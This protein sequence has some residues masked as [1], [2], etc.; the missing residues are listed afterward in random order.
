MSLRKVLSIHATSLS[1][2]KGMNRLINL[3]R[4]SA[5]LIIYIYKYVFLGLSYLN[6]FPSRN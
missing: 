6:N 2:F 4:H 3:Q 5:T 1:K